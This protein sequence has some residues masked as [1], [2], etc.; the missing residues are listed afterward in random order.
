MVY[1]L[2]V[3]D[4]L[5]L[6]SPQLSLF[7]L[8]SPYPTP[9][10]TLLIVLSFL[11]ELLTAEKAGLTAFVYRPSADAAYQVFVAL[12]LILRAVCPTPYPA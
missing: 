1:F 7:L 8:M 2:S 4:T 3:S 9:L 6:L 5:S 12:L 10:S 11:S